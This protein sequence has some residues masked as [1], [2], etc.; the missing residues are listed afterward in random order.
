MENNEIEENIIDSNN[1]V[2]KNMGIKGLYRQNEVKLPLID[3]K[4]REYSSRKDMK[5]PSNTQ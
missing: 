2:K 3:R 5:S 1:I 4:Y